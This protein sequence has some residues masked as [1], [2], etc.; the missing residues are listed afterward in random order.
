M[1]TKR[2]HFFVR[3]I[4]IILTMRYNVKMFDEKI[5]RH[6]P[7]LFPSP[8]PF[9]I[10]HPKKENN[11]RIGSDG[12]FYAKTSG[13]VVRGRLPV[14]RKPTESRCFYIWIV[15]QCV[16][17]VKSFVTISYPTRDS[18]TLAT[19]SYSISD[20]MELTSHPSTPFCTVK[21]SRIRWILILPSPLSASDCG[22]RAMYFRSR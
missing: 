12:Y 9:S 19:S 6:L 3:L 15:A 16:R 2:F 4:T 10:P 22:I 13:P 1:K 17:F 11:R 14:K 21:V 7:Q 18:K 5:P 20:G 8:R